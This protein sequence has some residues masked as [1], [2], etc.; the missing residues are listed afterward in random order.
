LLNIVT[1]HASGVEAVGA[2]FT[3]VNAGAATGGSW[4]P[5]TNITV[6]S[7]KKAPRAR[8]RGNRAIRIT[9]LQ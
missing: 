4:T 8:R 3:L 9:S 7:T 1:R 2:A 6:K 5:P